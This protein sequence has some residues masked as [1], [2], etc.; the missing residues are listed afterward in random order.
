MVLAL[1][2]TVYKVCVHD[3]LL[4]TQ[5]KYNVIYCSHNTCILCSKVDTL[6]SVSGVKK[7]AGPMSGLKLCSTSVTQTFNLLFNSSP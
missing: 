2:S 1:W 7:A 4:Y 6:H 5:Y 3:N